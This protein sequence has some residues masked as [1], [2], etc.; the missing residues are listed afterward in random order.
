MTLYFSNIK[1][2]KL[3]LKK[4]IDHHHYASSD[5]CS[6]LAKIYF[7]FF[8][9][10]TSD[11]DKDMIA[12]YVLYA[13][14]PQILMDYFPLEVVLLVFCDILLWVLFQNICSIR[15]RECVGHEPRFL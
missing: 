11:V 4:F 14:S 7:Y 2:F 5:H 6:R 8:Q 9:T 15:N 3:N 12:R 10:L 13:T 1:N